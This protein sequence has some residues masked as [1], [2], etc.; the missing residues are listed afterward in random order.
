MDIKFLAQSQ[1]QNNYCIHDKHS[2]FVFLVSK[3]SHK[4]LGLALKCKTDSF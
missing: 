1:A 2:I 4:M 3:Y